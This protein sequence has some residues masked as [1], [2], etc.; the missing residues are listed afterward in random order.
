MNPTRPCILCATDFSPHANNAATIAAKLALGR[1]EN[2]R[3]VHATDATSAT[4]LTTAKKHL[5]AE[6]QRLRQTGA[7]VEPLLLE[8]R[9]PSEALLAHIRAELPALVVVAS[10]V[11]GPIDRW[12]LGSFS[13]R[14]AESSPVPTLV[15]RNPAAF[16]RWDWS[17]DRLTI[18]LALDLHPTSDVVLRW[19]KAFR[20]AGP[21]DLAFCHVNRRMPTV[22]EAA[23]SPGRPVNPPTLTSRLKRELH[24]RVR[25]QFGDDDSPVMVRP[26]FGDPG[27]CILEIADE[28]KAQII[29]VGAHQRHGLSRL[30]QFSVSRELL[31]LSGTNVVCIPVTAKFDPREAHIPDFHRVLVATDFSELGNAAVPFACAGCCIGGL[32]R[33]VHVAPLRIPSRRRSGSGWSTDLREQL[34]SLIPNETGVRCQPPEFAVLEHGDVADAICA[35]ADRFGADLVCLS[36]HGLGASRALHGS[37]TKAVLKRIRRPL[38]VIRRPDE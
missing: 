20:M 16:E 35:E 36:S 11:K 8:G 6:A 5:E 24:K 14:V 22:E 10:G 4:A 27:P 31:H 37:V 23:I 30:A 32:V 19:A 33:I 34:R 12:A 3:L 2:L 26:Y 13:E 29:A 1:S 15:V 25:D 28:M 9:H 21:C 17:K 38:L 7:S 18:L